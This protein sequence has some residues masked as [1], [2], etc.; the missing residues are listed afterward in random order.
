MTHE[1]S[2]LAWTPEFP[3]QRPPFAPGNEMAMKHGAGSPRKVDPLAA[4]LTQ[5]LL[6]DDT[7][8]YLRSPRFASAVQAWA[9]AE[10]KCGLISNWVEG[11]SIED[12]ATSKPGQTSPLE[13]LRKWETTAQTH[14]ARLGLDPMSAAKLGKDI[15][16]TKQADVAAEMTR[17]REE[18]ERA[19]QG[20]I[21]GEV[22][23]HDNQCAFAGTGCWCVRGAGF[24]ASAVGSP[25]GYRPE[26][27]P[28]QGSVRWPAGG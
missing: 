8:S 15:A 13:L 28:V 3:G 21:P 4:E 19:T 16:Q 17:L 12:A 2:A 1:A 26:P 7:V 22:A 6:A 10:A 27:C 9:V 18:H 5:E 24:E 14:R 20:P 11:M 25:D 23:D